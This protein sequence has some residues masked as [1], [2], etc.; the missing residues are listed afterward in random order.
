MA[1]KL[2]KKAARFQGVC[3]IEEAETLL[4]WVQAQ[5]EPK[6]DLGECAHL[7]AALLQILLAH[8]V[9]VT[10]LPADPWLSSW[11]QE[12]HESEAPLPQ[13]THLDA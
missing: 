12:L 3:S 5:K 2:N 7:H 8:R 11:V 4:D 6:A 9:E 13:S 10:R 1:I